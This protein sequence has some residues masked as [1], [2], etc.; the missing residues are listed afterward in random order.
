MTEIPDRWGDLRDR[1]EWAEEVLQEMAE[2]AIRDGEMPEVY[3]RLAAKRSG[4]SLALSYMREYGR[5][6]DV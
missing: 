2:D 5:S 3:K 1:L 4:V 6:T